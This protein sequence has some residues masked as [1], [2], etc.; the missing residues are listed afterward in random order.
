VGGKVWTGAI[1]VV[2]AASAS[3]I[4]SLGYQT[5]LM[6]YGLGRYR[7]TDY[8]PGCC[9]GRL[10]PVGPVNSRNDWG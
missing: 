5:N 10:F 6:V 4:T 3:F 2:F 1:V 9:F 8:I 7:F